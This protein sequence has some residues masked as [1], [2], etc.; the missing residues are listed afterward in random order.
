MALIHVTDHAV[1]RYLERAK[2]LDVDAVR[3]HIAEVCTGPA[4]AG[5]LCVKTEGVKF[6]MQNGKVITCTPGGGGVNRIKRTRLAI[7]VGR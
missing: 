7:G 5:A 2:G 6:E 3:R 4:A 1:L